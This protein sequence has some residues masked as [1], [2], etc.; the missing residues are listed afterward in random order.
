MIEAFYHLKKLPFQKNINSE[1]LFMTKANL[2]LKNRFEYINQTREM[3]TEEE[4][5]RAS[6]E[7]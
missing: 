7:L 4:V 1:D 2:E 6:Q 3:M 5:Y